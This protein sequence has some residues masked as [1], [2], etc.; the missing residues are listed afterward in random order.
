MSKSFDFC[1]IGAGLAGLHTALELIERGVSVCVIDPNG[2]AGGASGT[3]VGLANPAT[4]RFASRT[5]MAEQSLS[6]LSN[7][8]LGASDFSDHS[9]YKKSGILRPALDEKIAS[10]MKKN[11]DSDPW[12]QGSVEWLDQRDLNEINSQ[13]FSSYGGVWVPNG[14]T[15]NIPEYLSALK[16]VT[17]N[18]GV[19]FILNEDYTISKAV[20]WNMKFTNNEL[21]SAANLIFTS[22]IW[23][24]YSEFWNGLTLHAVK[25][26]TL[27][28]ETNFPITFDHSV[29]ALG[30][31]S[32]I[33]G[34]TMILG[35]TYEHSFDNENPDE[36]GEKYI[37]ERLSKV[38]PL[39]S[40]S[41]TV[42]NNWAGVRA[43]TPDRKPFLGSNSTIDNCFVFAGLGS[44][45]LLYSSMGAKILVDHI[46]DKIAIPAEIS[47]NRFA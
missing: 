39:F 44:K 34:N 22:G 5:W 11:I 26:Q 40:D 2:I 43:S 10:K 13:V 47:L 1:V 18:L 31:F 32:K 37:I 19:E 33:S 14:L 46:L 23:T 16:K 45:G 42:L 15:V 25:G 41:I 4:G 28:V 3:P 7:R 6:S 38:F 17:E 20:D 12:M 21:A 24:R 35:S 30:Y 36:Q 29:S 27:I 8:L 9:F